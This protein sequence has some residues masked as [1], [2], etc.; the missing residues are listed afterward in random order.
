ML[1]SAI[2]VEDEIL[3]A[4]DIKFTLEEKNYKKIQIAETAEKALEYIKRERPELII[5]DIKLPGKMNGIEL[6]NKIPAK[7]NCKIIYVT[8]YTEA[9]YKDLAMETNPIAYITKPGIGWKLE[10][11]LDELTIQL[12]GLQ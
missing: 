5:I 6:A 12:E 2:V 10:E 8:A 3:I 4:Y 11:T 7:Y 9:P 1:N